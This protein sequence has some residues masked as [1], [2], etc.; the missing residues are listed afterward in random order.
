MHYSPLDVLSHPMHV[1][2]V[3]ISGQGH[4]SR[5][6]GRMFPHASSI[7]VATAHNI[8]VHVTVA[9]ALMA[10]VVR[11]IWP[12]PSQSPSAAQGAVCSAKLSWWLGPVFVITTA[13]TRGLICG[14]RHSHALI[15]TKPSLKPRKNSTLH[16]PQYFFLILG[17]WAG[18]IHQ[19][20]INWLLSCFSPLS[21][22]PPM[23]SYLTSSS[24]MT[25][26]DNMMMSLLWPIFVQNLFLIQAIRQ[27]WHSLASLFFSSTHL[28]WVYYVFF[29]LLLSSVR[30]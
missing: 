11:L 18:V 10:D 5:A 24:S 16:I 28:L 23:S 21:P 1:F 27:N 26:S 15:H 17:H 30:I 9:S 6:T 13:P 4:A 20:S 19:N 12:T 14:D 25:S 29:H 8:T 22:N 2:F 7:K 3:W